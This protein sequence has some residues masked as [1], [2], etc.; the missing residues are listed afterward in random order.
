M[1]HRFLVTGAS[2]QLGAYIVR[3]LIR[4]GHEVVAWSGTRA[5]DVQGVSARP[6]ELTDRD[7]VVQAFRDAESNIV[8]HPAAMAA[9]GDCARDPIRADAVNHRSTARLAELAAMA[10]ARFVFVSTD[11]VFDGEHA[12]YREGDS[13]APLSAYGRTKADAERAVVAL[14]NHVVV[15]VSL[16]FG[17]SI[18]GR[19]SF[20][21]KL[22]AALRT[23]QSVQLFHDEWRTPIGLA[24]AACALIEIATSNASGVLHLGGPERMSRL[25]MGQRLAAHLRISA[26]VIESVSR[27]TAAGE[28]RPRDT[29]LDST[30]WRGL[31]PNSPWPNFETALSGRPG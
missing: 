14:A 18:H 2:G 27:T 5:E 11:L 25:E 17:P 3:E 12:P 30:H 16:M 13:P 26:P 19:E 4:R 24:T 23:G 7:R 9:V 1:S 6:V 22:T 8:I 15:R 21:D 28:P 10:K 20:F 29:S 31:F